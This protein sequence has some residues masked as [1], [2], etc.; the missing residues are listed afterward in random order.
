MNNFW[1]NENRKCKNK[2]H[3]KIIK[4]S[5][6]SFMWRRKQC[7]IPSYHGQHT[8]RWPWSLSGRFRWFERILML[9]SASNHTVFHM[10]ILVSAKLFHQ[11]VLTAI[12]VKI[13][14]VTLRNAYQWFQYASISRDVATAKKNTFPM[15]FHEWMDFRSSSCSVKII[16]HEQSFR[17]VIIN[18]IWKKSHYFIN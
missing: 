12:E 15:C 7:E 5:F 10:R 2:I 9:I 11:I 17:F 3:N 8:S 13:R 18:F 16:S 4:C 14:D 1:F 6:L